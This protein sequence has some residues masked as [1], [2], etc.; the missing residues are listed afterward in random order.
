VSS[1]SPTTDEGTIHGAAL[2]E[3]MA[4]L[5][6]GPSSRSRTP[7]VFAATR[8]DDSH[9]VA[10]D[11]V[12]LSS[13]AYGGTY[14][15]LT[16]I[17]RPCGIETDVV[18]LSDIDMP[19]SRSWTMARS[20][21]GPRPSNPWLRIADIA[22]LAEVAHRHGAH[23]W[24]TTRSHA[25]PADPLP[26]ADVVMNIR[27]TVTSGDTPTPIGGMLVTNDA[28]DLAARL[29]F[30]SVCGGARYPSFGLLS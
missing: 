19:S 4:S 22:A 5:R 23:S 3:V 28:E 14:R 30:L 25:L 24:S 6:R 29:K 9:V 16:K 7:R 12:T 26:R 10:G 13:D 20:S 11:R 1:S 2:E 17:F 18:D 27:A 8:L 15:M 21:C